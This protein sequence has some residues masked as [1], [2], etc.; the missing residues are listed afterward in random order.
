[1]DGYDEEMFDD[2]A[3]DEA[4]GSADQGDEMDELDEFDSGDEMDEADEADEVDAYDEF[5]EA[6]EADS[7]DEFDEADETDEGDESPGSPTRTLDRV[8]AHALAAEDTDEFFRRIA[9]GVRQVAQV[10]RR[11]APV[12]GRI[13]RAA[14]PIAGMI[15]GPWGAAARVATNVLGRLRADEAS[16]EEVLDAFAELA[17]RNPAALPIAAAVATR[18][19]LGPSGARLPAAQREQ[20]VRTV[21]Q[22]ATRLVN[23]GG[24]TAIRALPRLARSVQRTA[25]ARRTPPAQR[26]QVLARTAARIAGR[27]TG[28]QRQLTRPLPTGREVLRRAGA[29][30]IAG[31]AR[32]VASAFGGGGYGGGGGGGG[33]GRGRMVFRRPRRV[34]IVR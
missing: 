3:I 34:I 21:R 10:A 16:E 26:P 22:A 5:D 18:R 25:V 6:D 23:N 19:M 13:A 28:L 20:A 4:E 33:R 27:G 15:P 12:V 1:M 2:L 11:V 17:V 9:R 8:M 30:A 24:P 29:G 14:A 32:G 7:Y 31:A